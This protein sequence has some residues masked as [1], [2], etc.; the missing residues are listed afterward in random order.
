MR[1]KVTSIIFLLSGIGVFMFGNHMS[2]QVDQGEAK[3]AQA[4]EDQQGRRK[5]LIGPV[6]KNVRSKQAEVAQQRI[7]AGKQN[8]ARS[9]VTANWL[10]GTG[11]SLFVV[12]VG[13]FIFSISS[14]K[15]A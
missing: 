1:K 8:I 2:K 11:I 9:Q 14:K 4:E 5:P 10:K 15:K 7:S 13:I 3:I 12:G 6:R